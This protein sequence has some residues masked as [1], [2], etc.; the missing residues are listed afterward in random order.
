[1]WANAQ[2]DSRPV[3]Y[4]WRPLLNATKFGSSAAASGPK[5][6]IL[7]GHMEEILLL[8]TFYSP[9]NCVMVPKWRFWRLFPASRVQHFS[10]LHSIL[11]ALGQHH[12]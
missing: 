4:R 12:V 1:M 10:D 9:K 5:C 7:C 6:A 2:R 3:E 8:N 11:F